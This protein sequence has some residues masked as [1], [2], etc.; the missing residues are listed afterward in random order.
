MPPC[1]HTCIAPPDLI[2][3]HTSPHSATPP[4]ARDA[5]I[6]RR[7]YTYT[8]PRYPLLVVDSHRSESSGAP[9][10]HTSIPPYFRVCTPAMRLQRSIP[11]YLR[12]ASPAARMR[13]FR[14]LELYA[15]TSARLQSA[16]RAPC[17]R[18]ATRTRRVPSYT[19]VSPYFHVCM[20]A[21]RSEERRVGKACR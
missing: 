1:R 9:E 4:S 17:L 3:R 15:S 7:Q 8:A 18:V 16:S 14:A 19:S 2:Q 5:Y 13:S 20:P 12:V 11:P 10:L 6:L 21:S